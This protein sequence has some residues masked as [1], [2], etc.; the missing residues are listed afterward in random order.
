V[1]A[2]GRVTGVN[3]R[4]FAGET[5]FQPARCVV[6]AC[7]AIESAR[8]LLLSRSERFPAGLANRSGNVGK[9]LVFSGASKGEALFKLAGRAGATWLL[10]RAPFVQ[11][12]MQDFYFRDK[13]SDGVRKAGTILFSLDHPNPIQKA[14]HVA[15]TGVGARWGARLK[16]GLRDEV[17][18]ARTLMF[19]TFAEAI[20]NAGTYVDLDPDVKD[21]WGTP[22]ARIT[23]E[24]HPLDIAANK[25][26]AARGKEV[27]DA[28]SPDSSRILDEDF[29]DM[30]LQG[31]TCRFGREPATNVLDVDCRAH[32]VPNLY[33]SDSSFM[34]TLGG[35]PPTMTIMANAFRVGSRLAA[36]F[37]AARI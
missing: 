6:V 29:Q 14:E 23:V 8:L 13:P 30:V 5:A 28:L 31:G 32:E 34:P 10:D 19:E 17:R 37:K 33:V 3:Y 12:S 25:L 1:N 35:V 11:R 24:R 2:E 4:T 21:R 16:Q 27:L 22:V 18:G 36:R 9:N 20:P 15:G 7:T 26:L